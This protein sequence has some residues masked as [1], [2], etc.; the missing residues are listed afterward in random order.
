MYDD[1]ILIQKIHIHEINNLMCFAILQAALPV[2]DKDTVE[3]WAESCMKGEL[4]GT[5]GVQETNTLL[6]GLKKMNLKNASVLV[7]GSEIPWVEA[8]VLAFEPHKITT[9]EYGRI[10]STHP[11]ILTMTPDE[12]RQNPHEFIGAFDAVITYSSVEHSGLGRYGDAMNPYGDRQTIA[13]AWC[14]AKKNAHLAVGLPYMNDED[15]IMYNAHR[16]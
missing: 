2:W 16:V 7:I 12:V 8:C 14:M 1:S 6:E 9:I 3:Q 11:K 5:Y 13:R 10:N 4:Q 15:H